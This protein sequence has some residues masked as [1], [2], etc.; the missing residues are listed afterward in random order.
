[1]TAVLTRSGL[2]EGI[3]E[4]LLSGHAGDGPPMLKAHSQNRHLPDLQVEP[5]DI[6]QGD[7]AVRLRIP[8]E[9]LNEGVQTFV[10]E[11][12]RDGIVLANFVIVAGAPVDEHLA[13]EVSLLRQELD[14]LK[15]AFRRHMKGQ[16]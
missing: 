4:G 6:D 15:R 13:A 2:R 8:P 3:W 11:D 16:E 14:M 5:V 7:W 9:C 1:M 12:E 10:I